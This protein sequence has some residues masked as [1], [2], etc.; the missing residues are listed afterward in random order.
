MKNSCKNLI[1]ILG[2]VFFAIA[3]T[4]SR[5]DEFGFKVERVVSAFELDDECAILK[6]LKVENPKSRIVSFFSE[7]DI[8]FCLYEV[9]SRDVKI[10]IAVISP[11]P[12]KK[13]ISLMV[14]DIDTRKDLGLAKA[15]LYGQVIDHSG[16]SDDKSKI[17]EKNFGIVFQLKGHDS[18]VF[19]VKIERP[20]GGGKSWVVK[21]SSNGSWEVS[22]KP[23]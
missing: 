14:N 22:V 3:N 23:I 18:C 7:N 1:L 19:T 20:S 4:E 16:V 11:Q 13:E 9:E 8:S 17:Y 10:L 21:R 5:A 6:M 12:Q 2:V 15:R